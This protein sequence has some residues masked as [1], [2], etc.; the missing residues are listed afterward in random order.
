MPVSVVVG[1]QYGSEGKGKVVGHLAKRYSSAIV[2]RVGGPNS[3]HTVLDD[4]GNRHI[5][6]QLP[7]TAALDPSSSLVIPPGAYL[8][9]DVLRS[10]ID[11]YGVGPNRL[12]IDPRAFIVTARHV[13]REVGSR[14]GDSIG[15]TQSGTGAAVAERVLRTGD[16]TLAKSVSYLRPFLADTNE[17]LASAIDMD[18]RIIVEGTQG[19]GLSLLHGASYPFATSR[20]T[21]A[22]GALSEAGISPL[23]VDDIVLVCRANAIRVSGH[24]GPLAGETTWPTIASQSGRPDLCEYTTVTGRVRRIGNFNLDEVRRALAV[25]RPTTLVLNHADYIADASTHDG[26]RAISDSIAALENQLGRKFDLVGMD[27]R[28]LHERRR[29][30]EHFDAA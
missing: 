25:N 23:A 11:A 14:M 10:E 2:V 24:S 15:S 22:A 1:A 4:A 21:S 19:F 20:D 5:L 30:D 17:F 26:R 18:R 27:P 7:V 9:L 8:N 16:S 3:G 12:T 29:L 13:T 28:G 6:R